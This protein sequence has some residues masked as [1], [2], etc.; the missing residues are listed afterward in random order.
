[1][2]FC[3]KSSVS[4][5]YFCAFSVYIIFLFLYHD[6]N[7][8]LAVNCKARDKQ[9]LQSP[10]AVLVYLS[11]HTRTPFSC[12]KGMLSLK[13]GCNPAFCSRHRYAVYSFFSQEAARVTVF[14]ELLVAHLIK[15]LRCL[16]GTRSLPVTCSCPELLDSTP[17]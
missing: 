12:S 3:P 9:V 13:D 17:V 5:N 10:V 8:S 11:V 2:F 4:S 15:K 7:K 1:M 14:I 16:R 6:Y